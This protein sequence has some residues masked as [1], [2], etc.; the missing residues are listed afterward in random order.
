MS[1]VSGTR[2]TAGLHGI[3]IGDIDM[4]DAS[5]ISVP[6][7]RHDVVVVVEE[8]EEGGEEEEEEGEKAGEEEE[9]EEWAR[10][11][12]PPPPPPPEF[13]RK[14]RSCDT[15][16]AEGERPTTEKVTS[17]IVPYLP[18]ASG[19]RPACTK[20]AGRGTM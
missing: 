9:E 11:T 4:M 8:E 12:P 2:G 1:A 3:G 14:L 15:A 20:D 19:A 5:V 18:A 16:S 13:E 7:I 10:L 6:P 17:L